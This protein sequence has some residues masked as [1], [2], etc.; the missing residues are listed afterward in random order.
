[1]EELLN[2]TSD[3]KSKSDLEILRQCHWQN[4]GHKIKS[5]LRPPRN[6]Y[7]LRS[8]RFHESPDF[9]ELVSASALQY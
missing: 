7:Q 9:N 6:G 1:M 3:P 4:C 2:L 5:M 8:K